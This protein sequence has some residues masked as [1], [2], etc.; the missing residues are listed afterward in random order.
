MKK[1]KENQEN[2]S[3]QV[4]LYTQFLYPRYRV[5]GSNPA[6][7]LSILCFCHIKHHHDVAVFCHHFSFSRLH[8]FA[9]GLFVSSRFL[10]KKT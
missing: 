4:N 9:P 7:I 1:N 10:G 3:N 6:K 2:I 5:V 8:I